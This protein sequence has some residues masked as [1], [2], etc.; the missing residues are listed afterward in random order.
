MAYPDQPTGIRQVHSPDGDGHSQNRGFERRAEVLFD[1]DAMFH[2]IRRA[3]RVN[4]ITVG[5]A[6]VGYSTRN[7]ANDRRTEWPR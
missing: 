2:Q 4:W 7:V 3:P 5:T 6:R 1:L